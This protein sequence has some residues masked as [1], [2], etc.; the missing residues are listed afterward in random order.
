MS[1]TQ[2]L[3]IRGKYG[4]KQQDQSPTSRGSRHWN[5]QSDAAKELSYAAQPHEKGGLG[6]P[7]RH[8][9]LIGLRHDKVGHP[10]QK[11]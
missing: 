5:Q 8:H 10:A 4:D 6:Q 3:Y 7:R 11:E 1:Q 9:S 2:H